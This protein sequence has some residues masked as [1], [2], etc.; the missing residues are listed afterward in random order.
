M[1]EFDWTKLLMALFLGA[2]LLYLLP[3]AKHMMQNSPKAEKGDWQAVLI[4]IGFVVLF[5]L[6][7]ISLV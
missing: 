5:I 2:M 6:F 3:R 7:L 1:E 4:P